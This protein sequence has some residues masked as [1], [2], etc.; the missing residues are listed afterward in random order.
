[1]KLMFHVGGWWSFGAGIVSILTPKLGAQFPP[2]MTPVR[3]A[4]IVG[5]G[6]ASV[7]TNPIVI[8]MHCRSVSEYTAMY[9]IFL[10]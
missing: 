10:G 2:S 9:E 7:S 6:S 8:E 1:M 3:S 4:F 5:L